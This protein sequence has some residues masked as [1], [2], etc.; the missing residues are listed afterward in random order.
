MIGYC[1]DRMRTSDD[2][3]DRALGED[4]AGFGGPDRWLDDSSATPLRGGTA[5]ADRD[6]SGSAPLALL[7]GASLRPAVTGE[8]LASWSAGLRAALGVPLPDLTLLDGE[9]APDQIE[10]LS[11]GQRLARTVF[12]PDRVRVSKRRWEASGG[13]SADA[14]V[15]LDRGEEVLWLPPEVVAARDERIPAEDL[16]QAVTGWL[17]GHVRRSFDLIFDVQL[18]IGFMREVATTADGR[19]RLVQIGRPLLRAVLVGLVQDGVRIGRRRDAILQE[20]A[21]LALRT[22]EPGP[23]LQRIRVFVKDEI[24]A[25]IAGVS[26]E[27]TT[28]L[29]AER[30]EE[31]L[32]NIVDD[33]V[34]RFERVPPEAMRLEAALRR[35]LLRIE[36]DGPGPPAVLVTVPPLRAALADLLRGLDH[37]L[38]VL[39]FTELPQDLTTVPGGLVDVVA[40][41]GAP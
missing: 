27:V 28:I 21:D 20:L 1:V 3:N 14:L 24:C 7:V 2:A 30:L 41:P 29:L 33:A 9:T 22:R 25:A 12:C 32:A 6:L 31:E 23:V 38:P 26:G 4:L 17:E 8:R 36:Q 19:R 15:D 35:I 37:R 39:G 13:A 5:V 10:L 40:D 34:G 11:F 16:E 18:E